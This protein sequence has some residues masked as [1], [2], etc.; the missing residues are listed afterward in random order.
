MNASKD[1]QELKARQRAVWA[2][3]DYPAVAAAM[4]PGLGAELVKACAI[5]PGQ[6]VLDV[7]GMAKKIV[8]LLPRCSAA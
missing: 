5:K 3:G 1:D 4:I 6:R 8:V 2:S 7:S